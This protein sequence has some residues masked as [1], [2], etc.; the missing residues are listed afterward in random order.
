MLE[1]PATRARVHTSQP[2]SPRRVRNVWR[3]EYTSKGRSLAAFRAFLCWSFRLS[4]LICSSFVCAGQ[5]QPSLGCSASFHRF[6]NTSRTRGDSGSA[7]RAAFV[8][9]S[10]IR[11]NP[12]LPRSQL[13]L[14]H[15]R[16]WHSSGRIPVSNSTRETPRNRTQYFPMGPMEPAEVA[17]DEAIALGANDIGHLQPWPSHFFCR[18]R[19]GWISPPGGSC[20]LSRGWGTACKC[21]WE[22][23]R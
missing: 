21:L 10:V 23:C 20:R 2:L 13:M 4:W 7:R 5:T 16:Q 14:S 6:S 3:I 9:P 15:R 11:S 18:L 17:V 22:R 1:C 12:F 8:L 19:E